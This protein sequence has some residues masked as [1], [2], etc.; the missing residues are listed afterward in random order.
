MKYCAL[1]L[2]AF[3]IIS[4]TSLAQQRMPRRQGS[5]GGRQ[6][7]NARD[8]NAESVLPYFEGVLKTVDKK[9]FYLETE[10]GNTMKFNVVK[11]TAYFNGDKKLKID[12]FKEGE[13]IS[14]E[15]Q[16]APDRTFDAVFVRTNKKKDAP[17]QD[18]GP[19]KFSN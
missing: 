7:G 16:F 10:D 12:D 14:V 5:M 4:E 9:F 3:F 2:V 1:A 19:V 18:S 15:A 13:P 11:K 8:K 17:G 6:S